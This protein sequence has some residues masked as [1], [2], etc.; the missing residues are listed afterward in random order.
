[1]GLGRRLSLIRRRESLGRNGLLVW[2]EMVLIDLWHDDLHSVGWMASIAAHVQ[3]SPSLRVGKRAEWAS[4]V[5]PPQ[6]DMLSS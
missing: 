4:V 6:R 2:S 5:N 3:Y 1:M